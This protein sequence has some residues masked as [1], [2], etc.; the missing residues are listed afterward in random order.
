M[1]VSFARLHGAEPS[2]TARRLLW[3]VLSAGQVSRDEPEAHDGHDKAG[4]HLFW[5][6]AGEGEL[7]VAGRRVPLTCGPACWLVDLTAPRRYLPGQ[8]TALVTEGFRFSG[9][10][11]EAWRQALG[12]GRLFEP[13][14]RAFAELRQAQQTLLRLIRRRPAGHEWRCHEVLTEV[15][16]RLLKQARVLEGP[17]LPAPEPVA[18]VVRAVLAD[19]ERDWKAAELAAVAGVSYSGLRQRFRQSQQEGLHEFLQRTRLE[20]ARLLLGDPALSVKE[21]AHRLRFSSEMYFSHFF[22]R[23]EGL[24]PREYRAR[25]RE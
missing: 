8:G 2:A 3:H 25:L 22:R 5:V 14:P 12:N 16:G 21:V 1:P 20:Q 11:V 13:G 24:C 10:G 9:P 7:E 17:A 4:A 18:R 23:G 15:L 6:V 19:P